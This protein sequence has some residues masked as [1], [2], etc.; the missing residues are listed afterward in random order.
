MRTITTIAMT[1]TMRAHRGQRRRVFLSVVRG[2]LLLF[3]GD[4]II[5]CHFNLVV[6]LAQ[7]SGSQYIIKQNPDGI[8]ATGVS[9]LKAE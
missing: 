6:R 3:A 7:L 1:R 8:F 9:L 4:V 2:V 5:E